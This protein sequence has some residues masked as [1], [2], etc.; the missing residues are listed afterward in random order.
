MFVLKSYTKYNCM[1]CFAW[2]WIV[3]TLG[4]ILNSVH[5]HRWK[6]DTYFYIHVDLPIKVLCLFRLVC[7]GAPGSRV[8]FYWALAKNSLRKTVYNASFLKSLYIQYMAILLPCISF[9]SIEVD[10]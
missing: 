2:L 3:G 8:K 4:D 7:T 10:H 9:G 1:F 6:T 5:N